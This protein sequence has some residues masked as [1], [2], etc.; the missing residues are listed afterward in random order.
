M[1][2]KKS[3][4]SPKSS[5]DRKLVNEKENVVEE[6]GEYGYFKNESFHACMNFVLKC[7]G[8]VEEVKDIY[9]E[10]QVESKKM[11]IGYMIRAKQRNYREETE[12]W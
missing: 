3:L 4:V 5:K 2:S 1:A 9:K 12:T 6:N 8:I 7:E 10:G 11:V